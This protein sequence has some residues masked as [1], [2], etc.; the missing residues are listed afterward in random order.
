MELRLEKSVYD[1]NFG[2]L[3]ITLQ[4]PIRNRFVYVKIKDYD[5]IAINKDPASLV[6]IVNTFILVEHADLGIDGIFRRNSWYISTI[7]DLLK[8][9]GEYT[10]KTTYLDNLKIE[11]Y[12]MN[13]NGR[14]PFVVRILP[15]S[16][17]IELILSKHDFYSYLIDQAKNHVDKTDLLVANLKS[18]EYRE[19]VRLIKN[20]VKVEKNRITFNLMDKLHK[21]AFFSSVFAYSLGMID[22]A[23]PFTLA[24]LPN[25][26]SRINN[27][28]YPISHPIT[29]LDPS[30]FRY[31]NNVWNYIEMLVTNPNYRNGRTQDLF[32]EVYGP[33]ELLAFSQKITSTSYK[34][35]SNE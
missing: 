3:R 20:I 1:P 26:N 9:K 18:R 12:Y 19:V 17:G 35:Q 28:L 14:R 2:K 7:F 22:G 13:N 10:K 30:Y 4:D 21:I 25:L 23:T 11:E 27:V 33:E 31:F 5:R 15:N 34:K 24:N 32:I 6:G 29:R 8:L 16:P